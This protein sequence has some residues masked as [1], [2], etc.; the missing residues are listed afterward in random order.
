MNIKLKRVN[1]AVH[2]EM[3]NEEGIAAYVDGA[4]RIGGEGKGVRPKELVLM[5]AAACSTI[6]IVLILKKM[7][8]QLDDIQAE[9]D[10]D[11]QAEGEHSILRKMHLTYRLFG[12]IKPHKAFEAVQM[13]LEKYCSVT[14]TLEATAEITF[15]VHL[16]GARIEG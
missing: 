14:K 6:D 7:R 4:P 12:P 13:S 5:G 3:T 1:D 16:N 10:G 9:T 8:Q 11:W 15:E 2:F